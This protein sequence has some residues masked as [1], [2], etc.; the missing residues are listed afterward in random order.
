MGIRWSKPKPQPATPPP[1]AQTRT[2]ATVIRDEQGRGVPGAHATLNDAVLHVGVTD[3]N[4]YV[5]WPGVLASLRASDVAVEVTGF[6]P[7]V[8]HV[9]VLTDGD[10]D[11]PPITL[12]SLAPPE[13]EMRHGIVAADGR[14]WIDSDG[15]WSPLGATLL[16][17]LFDWYEGDRAR[18]RQHWAWLHSKHVDHYRML[19]E[20]GWPGQVINPDAPNY[21]GALASLIDAGYD[22]YGLRVFLTVRGGGTSVD[23]LSLARRVAAIVKVR[24]QKVFCLEAA[25]ESFQNGPDD[26]TILQMVDILKTAGVL[27]IGSSPIEAEYAA[28]YARAVHA[29]AAAMHS[30]RTPGDEGWRIARQGWLANGWGLIGSNAEPPGPRSSVAE[31]TDPIKLAMLRAVGI[32]SG[33]GAF[34]IHN[35][36]GVTGRV[37]PARN[38]PANLWEVPGIDDI[39]AAVWQV[40]QSLPVDLPNWQ[41]FN[42]G[43]AGAPMTAD[44][45]WTDGADHGCV[46]FYMAEKGYEAIGIVLGVKGYVVIT[47][48]TAMD[49]SAL[50]PLTGEVL[51]TGR[52]KAGNTFTL[53]GPRAD[54]SLATGA[55]RAFLVKAKM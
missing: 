36:A 54:G 8:A 50:D 18:V 51:I 48:N 46:R 16:W 41:K 13:P 35:G 31:A 9:D 22:E 45:F 38:R 12:T 43:W 6:E 53:F 27:V 39:M 3:D 10:F 17:A 2:V 32:L 19:G 28:A 4:G 11:L 26:A 21:D 44:A 5:F 14:V 23:S 52:A 15:P 7:Y 34:V 30:D 42:N 55:R 24:P 40:G 37:D 25:N 1:V 49:F 47:A 20:V 33:A 29:T